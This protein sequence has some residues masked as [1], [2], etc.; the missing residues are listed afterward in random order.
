MP[1]TEETKLRTVMFRPYAKGRGPTFRLVTW[2][3][4]RMSRHGKW[5]VGYRL[6]MYDP[7]KSEENPDN[8]PVVLFEGEDYGCAP[9]FAIDSDRAVESI[10]SF[11]TLRPG[12]TDRDYFS[13]YTQEQLDYCARHAQAL[14]Q[15]VRNRFGE[16]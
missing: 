8:D 2:D 10:M 13:S 14:A 1:L 3:V 4:G 6:T 11:L 12:D 16:G 5:L 9:C 15:E 7:G